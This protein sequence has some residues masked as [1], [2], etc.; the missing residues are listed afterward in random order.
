MELKTKYQYSYFIY[1]FI[2]NENK[3]SKYIMS[4]LKNKNC[5]MKFFEKEKDLNI[6]THFLPKIRQYMF[7]TFGYN[8]AK[9]EKFE[10]LEIDMKTAIIAKQ[11]CTIFEYDMGKN[12][13]GKVSDEDGIFFDIPNI[14][15]VCFNT[16]VC[17]ILIKTTLA[18][19]SVFSEVLNFN[20]K[21]KDINSNYSKL[22]DTDNIKIR[23]I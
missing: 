4:L 20:C 8:K 12:I 5:N 22:S 10:R 11:P 13:Q 16:G 6:Y 14:E 9:R 3:Y 1:P 2:V 19:N 21:F 23:N 18:E 15:I 17:F 7:W